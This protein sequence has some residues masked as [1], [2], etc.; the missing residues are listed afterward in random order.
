M[1][2][3]TCGREDGRCPRAQRGTQEEVKRFIFVSPAGVLI[4]L[5]LFCTQKERVRRRPVVSVSG[6]GLPEDLH[7]SQPLVCSWQ[8]CM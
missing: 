3:Q 2:P 5:L 7:G 8:S 6:S 4:T 1:C